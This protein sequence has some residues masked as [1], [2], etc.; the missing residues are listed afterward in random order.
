MKQ[1]KKDLIAKFFIC[2]F[3]AFVFYIHASNAIFTIL[4]F[5]IFTIAFTLMLILPIFVIIY[6]TKERVKKDV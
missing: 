6:K 1:N 4:D 3:G 2:Y 5:Y